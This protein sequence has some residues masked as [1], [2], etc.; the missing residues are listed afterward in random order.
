M[1]SWWRRR[2]RRRALSP[3][4]V[5]LPRILARRYGGKDA[6]SAKQVA[7]AL[8][9]FKLS[10]NPHRDAFAFAVACDAQ[11]FLAAIPEAPNERQLE[12]RKEIALL[13]ELEESDLA[14]RRLRHRKPRSAFQT[15]DPEAWDNYGRL[16]SG[17]N[18]SGDA[19]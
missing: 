13:F 3:I 18:G 5:E 9:A 10:A 15:N 16:G 12:L 1:L 6:Y 2:Q 8:G 17:Q 7:S 19:P 4:V 14:L 11:E